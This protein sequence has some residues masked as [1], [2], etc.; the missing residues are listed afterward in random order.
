[1]T[2]RSSS[3]IPC[4]LF[5]A[6]AGCPNGIQKLPVRSLRRQ[7]A[8]LP[9]PARYELLG[10]DGSSGPSHLFQPLRP[11][12]DYV[13]RECGA[14]GGRAGRQRRVSAFVWGMGYGSVELVGEMLRTRVLHSE[15]T[16]ARLPNQ[17][18]DGRSGL[19][20]AG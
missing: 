4:R 7:R 11:G 9:P 15:T 10:L 13:H 17:R 12:H 3:N 16:T 8:L 5:S 19:C 14:E 2:T 18:S 20:A 6:A 1:M